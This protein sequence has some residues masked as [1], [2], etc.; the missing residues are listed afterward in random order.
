M[1]FKDDVGNRSASAS[2]AMDKNGGAEEERGGEHEENDD[3]EEAKKFWR[4]CVC[5]CLYV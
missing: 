5:V 4:V 3:V 1:C 2:N